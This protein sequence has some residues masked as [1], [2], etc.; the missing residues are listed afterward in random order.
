MTR[1]TKSR[2]LMQNIIGR[3]RNSL[4]KKRKPQQVTKALALLPLMGCRGEEKSEVQE[5]S[6]NQTT[7]TN[8]GINYFELVVSKPNIGSI[9][10]T[11]K[12]TAT[13]DSYSTDTSL[14]DENPYDKDELTVT[15]TDDITATPTIRGI[16]IINFTTSETSLGNDNEFDVNLLNISGTEIINFENTNSQSPIVTLDI[17]NAESELAFG[18]HFSTAKIAAKDNTDLFLTISSDMT[19]STTG[20]SRNLTINGSGENITLAS[21]ST[22]GNITINNANIVDINTISSVDNLTAVA[23]GNFSLTNAN[24]LQGNINVRSGGTI[25]VVNATNATGT[26]TLSNERAQPGSD[27]TLTNVNSFGN[28]SIKSVG[29]I[30]A[31]TN[32][33][34]AA[35]SV[36][37]ATAAEDSTL[38]A[39][40][41]PNQTISLN[42]VNTEGNVTQFSLNA[43]S[44]EQLNLGGSSPILVV[45][46]GSDLSTETVATTNSDATLWLSG[47]DTDLRNVATS[48]KLRLK[49]HDGNTL[50]IKDS[51][52][53]Y[54]DAEFD[55]TAA[56]AKPIFDHVTD[57][58]S[59][60]TN[61]ISIKAFDSDTS[62]GDSTIAIAGLNF[63]DIQTLNLQLLSAIGLDSS[64]D[65]TGSDLKSVV[66]TGSGSFD[67]NSNTITGSSTNR[68]TLDASS[69]TGAVTLYL[70]ATS[71]GIANIKTGSA[72]DII[73]I[74][75]ITSASA[76]YVIETNAAAD[77][78]NITTSGDGPT[79]KININGGTGTDT[80]ILDAG[81]DLSSSTVSLTAVE[82]IQLKG[83]GTSQKIS[84]SDVS[85]VGFKL[86]RSGVGPAVLTVVA[87]QTTINLS[88]FSFDSSFA[89]GTDSILVDASGAASGV[90]ITGT[91]GN[92]TITGSNA[93]DVITGGDAAD[94]I[95]AGT[96]DDIIN[97][98]NG[99]DTLTG[100]AGD[101]EFD[102]ASGSSTESEMDKIT[103]YQAA[104]A[105][106]HNDKIDNI[107]G[108]VGADTS[109]VDVKSAISGGGGGE[110]VKAAVANGIVTLSGA[111]AGSINTLAEWIDAVSVDGVIAVAADDADSTGTVAFQFNGNTYLVESNDS[112][113]N[114]TPNVSIVSVIELTGLTGVAAVADAA[115]AATIFIA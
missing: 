77:A 50:T 81:V 15:V 105:D 56:T 107:T 17:T 51:Q 40:G 61:A 11:D 96:G 94:T 78:I 74:N 114:N 25:H 46:D 69:S 103:D 10:A 59:H 72:S 18:S 65:I 71:N 48:V 68:V 26:L 67:L 52:D 32:G 64:A 62:N 29:S 27:I 7:S 80:L 82:T 44:L 111:D 57:A 89:I 9:E 58:T 34:F 6:N 93:N 98:G 28:I 19:I 90:T 102:F 95:S 12:I 16:E 63:T 5:N 2:F 22:T 91:S 42:A 113:N 99:A 109:N 97:G 14:T 83:G 75:G 60:T 87:D 33:G 3:I 106:A 76:G 39:D 104:A 35:A 112:F 31:T 43:S 88:P 66:V 4:N 41:V 45:L 13:N 70:D 54:L 108:A 1:D 21:S 110:T 53:F 73:T 20:S 49:N 38:N 92:D 86:S 47:A 85:G 100:G 36:I 8:D 37:T 30:T 23:N 79:A 24:Q 84:A 101:D 115:A 55:Q